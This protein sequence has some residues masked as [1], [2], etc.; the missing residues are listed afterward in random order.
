[1]KVRHG[2]AEK[3]EHLEYSGIL[4]GREWEGDSG[5]QM[6][7][8]FQA[9]VTSSPVRTWASCFNK[10]KD[11]VCM[12]GWVQFRMCESE[13]FTDHPVGNMGLGIGRWVNWRQMESH[14]LKDHSWNCPSEWDHWGRTWSMRQI[15]TLLTMTRIFLCVWEIL[16]DR[17]KSIN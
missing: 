3:M 15:S 10:K 14:P 13:M 8:R 9:Q 7:L 2:A 6:F 5:A 16:A 17:G 12:E 4:G 1:M 11:Y